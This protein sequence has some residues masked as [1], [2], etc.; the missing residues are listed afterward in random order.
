MKAGVSIFRDHN[1]VAHVKA[2]SLADLYWGQGFA[3][4]TDRLMQM[5]LMR[6]LGQGRV[7]E[8]LHDDEESL[9]I[10]RF[11]R[12]MNWS[13]NVSKELE[14]LNV[15]D[16]AAI[17]SYCQGINSAMA[18]STPWEFKLLGYRPEPFKP[19]DCLLMSRMLGY[20]TLAQSQGEIE[21]LF[22]EMVQAGIDKEKLDELFPGILEGADYE[23][24]GK[25]TL[26]E[27]IVKPAS[28]WNQAIPRMMASNNWVVHGRK[29][30][31]GKPLLANDPHLEG[32]RLPNVWY[33]VVLVGNDRYMMGA[34]LPGIPGILSGR[35]NDVSWGVTYA[36]I[37]NIDSWIEQIESGRY[38]RKAD[39]SWHEFEERKEVIR[40]KNNPSVVFGCYENEHGLLD[41][42]PGQSGYYLVTKWAANDAGAASISAAINLWQVENVS[43]A[44]KMLAKIESGWSFVMADTH[45]DIAFQM[46][47]LVPMRKKGI[48]GFVPLPGW[49]ESNNWQGFY[50]PHLLPSCQNPP[51]GFFATANQNLN[52]YGAV[53]PINM[54]MG[55]YRADRIVA[56]LKENNSLGCD[57]MYKM[58]FDVYSLQ[59]EQFMAIL[60]PLLPETDQGKILE[61]WDYQYDAKSKGAYLFELFLKCLYHDVFAVNGLGEKIVK[62]LDKESGT[63]VDFYHNFDLVLLQ[64]ESLW[65]NE[66]TREEIY[67]V[68]V[69]RALKLTP[70]KWGQVQR[71]TLTNMFFDGKMPDIL[72]FDKGPITAIGGRASI[73]QGQIYRH[74]GRQSTFIPTFRSVTDMSKHE[75]HTCL[76]GGPSDRRFSKWYD[77]GIGQ[78]QKGAYKLIS[79]IPKKKLKFK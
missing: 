25:I 3:H 79:P 54:A 37:D 19:K 66:K 22:V 43:Q 63:F 14:K 64:P 2:E 5:C 69:T 76:L 27:R 38:F 6:V 31:S 61:K 59:A 34:S 50:P 30:K 15:E 56:L 42:D 20:L 51:D 39:D 12:R 11:F 58:Q 47:G 45:G 29:T 18:K 17:E 71:F 41:G 9:R 16:H 4:G 57:D 53:K 8:L 44:M 33:E 26:G 23:L 21:R 67:R 7:C 73:H 52:D 72:G 77:S 35:N 46:S 75:L 68:A 48:S 62:Y 24:I 28:L 32:N 13:K 74:D 10:D 49:D 55:P 70:K 78:W 36:F 1:G 60:K 40:R 65:F